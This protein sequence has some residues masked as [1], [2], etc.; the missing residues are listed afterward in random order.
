MRVTTS[1]KLSWMLELYTNSLRVSSVNKTYIS[2]EEPTA[3]QRIIKRNAVDKLYKVQNGFPLLI[4][5][6]A[7]LKALLVQ[8]DP[9]DSNHYPF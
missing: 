4:D 8:A 3:F 1:F 9:D 7:E 5:E 6:I 2:L